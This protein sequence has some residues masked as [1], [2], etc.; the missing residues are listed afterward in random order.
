MGERGEARAYL[1]L[2]DL[3]ASPKSLF[4]PVFLGAK[5]EAL[6]FY[7]EV[8]GQFKR[9]P[10]FF[11]QV[12]TTKSGTNPAGRLK[13]KLS[14][15]DVKKLLGIS[16]PTYLVGVDDTAKWSYILSI[17]LPG[18]K[19]LGSM[20]TTFQLTIPNLKLL[21]DEV[22]SFWKTVNHKPAISNF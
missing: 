15:S 11:L 10:Y 13:V 3:D 18:Q 6:D 22:V 17:H 8:V 21:K 7:V 5:F 4:K 19:S 16:A 14:K 2:T 1:A 9:K 12:K 20:P